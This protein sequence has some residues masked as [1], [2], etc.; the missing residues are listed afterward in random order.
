MSFDVCFINVVG[1]EG[2]IQFEKVFLLNK[3]LSPFVFIIINYIFQL[4]P[5]ST[6]SI[7]T[8]F[9]CIAQFLRE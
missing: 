5:T 3:V 9:L 6:G 4:F 1:G 2:F 7:Y 8:S